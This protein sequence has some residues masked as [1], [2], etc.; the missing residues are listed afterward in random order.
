MKRILLI[1]SIVAAA[2][3]LFAQNKV[4]WKDTLGNNLPDTVE[5][6]RLPQ[7]EQVVFDALISNVSS[8]NFNVL[9][10]RTI[11]TYLNGA[12]DQLCYGASCQA[13]DIGKPL[14]TTS[15]TI[16]LAGTDVRTIVPIEMIHYIPEELTGT[17][18]LKYYIC[19]CDIVPGSNNKDSAINIVFTDSVVVN[20]I[21][22]PYKRV[23]LKFSI[24]MAD[25]SSFD[26]TRD[27]LYVQVF[28][29]STSLG[30][31]KMKKPS[32]GFVFTYTHSVDNDLKYTYKY[33]YGTIKSISGIDTVGEPVIRP[34]I[35]VL[36][37]DEI[38]FN[39]KWAFTTSVNS[40]ISSP[41]Q[42][43]PNPFKNV[44]TIENMEN[45]SKVEISNILGQTV[46]T[47]KSVETSLTLSTNELNAGI[48]FVRV[49][50]ANNQVVTKRMVKK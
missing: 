11:V 12:S 18:S 34:A 21:I 16:Q 7:H 49:T 4:V 37:E 13:G 28:E 10:K 26:K 5:L 20:Y 6:F 23:D 19:T 43:Y 35:S 31:R 39:D 9:L 15:P 22:E 29:K 17:T 24:D 32:S 14:V 44:L 50:D 27:T 33:Y 42:I 41:V 46:Y 30:L 1:I 45:A 48:Y 47:N 25:V 36:H 2:N 40:A 8:E 3:G 38:L